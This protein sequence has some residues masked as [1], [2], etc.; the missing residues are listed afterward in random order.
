MEP[1]QSPL[2]SH[3]KLPSTELPS[4]RNEPSLLGVNPV[5]VTVTC[6]LP[7]WRDLGDSVIDGVL[8]TFDAART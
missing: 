5:P 8:A 7:A 4:K 2:P 1:E 6:P 3:E